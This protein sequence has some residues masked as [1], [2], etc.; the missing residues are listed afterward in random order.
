MRGTATALAVVSPLATSA[1][2]FSLPAPALTPAC[3]CALGLQGT[4]SQA[5][6]RG[7]VAAAVRAADPAVDAKSEE[8]SK[9]PAAPSRGCHTLPGCRTF[10][11]PSHLPQLARMA[12]HHQPL[13]HRGPGPSAPRSPI[14]RSRTQRAPLGAHPT[15]WTCCSFWDH[16]PGLAGGRPPG[17]GAGVA[18]DSNTSSPPR[19]MERSLRPGTGTR[20]ESREPQGLQHPVPKAATGQGVQPRLWRDQRKARKVG[21]PRLGGVLPQPQGPPPAQQGTQSRRKSNE[22]QRAWKSNMKDQD[23]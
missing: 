10:P 20:R 19:R 15:W 9:G 18:D 14:P 2:R 16:R 12:N 1:S 11:G 13:S 4:P 21:G 23:T 22:K 3:A 17:V 7:G 5:R 6:Q 8:E